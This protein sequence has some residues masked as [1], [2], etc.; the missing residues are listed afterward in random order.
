V[1]IAGSMLRTQQPERGGASV[2]IRLSLFLEE[3]IYVHPLF[4]MHGYLGST[5]QVLWCS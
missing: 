5:L 3:H 4:V 1:D 2:V